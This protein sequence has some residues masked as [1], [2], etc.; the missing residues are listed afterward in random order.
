MTARAV[1]LLLLL[2]LV[3][4]ASW[5]F[6][7]FEQYEREEYVGYRGE[8]RINRYLGTQL[9]L[10]AA[11]FEA[12][13]LDGIELERWLPPA[14]DT[15]LL[16]QSL[17]NDLIG[18]R[19]ALEAWLAEGGHL[20][21]FPPDIETSR[22]D[23]L[24]AMAGVHTVAVDTADATAETDESI[25]GYRLTRPI[26][27]RRLALA[28]EATNGG[29]IA[30]IEDEFGIVAA[31]L[32]RGEGYLTVIVSDLWLTNGLIAEPESARF[33]LDLLAGAIE[34]GKVWI[35]FDEAI[36]GLFDRLFEAMPGVLAGIAI[37]V[38]LWLWSVVPRFGPLSNDSDYARRSI[39][40]HLEAAGAFS[41]RHDG[42]GSLLD[43]SIDALVEDAERRHPGLKKLPPE[44]QAVRIAHIT[45]LPASLIARA[46]S[47]V[48]E[49]TP[50][51]FTHHMQL[52][53]KVRKQL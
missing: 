13:S 49:L 21:T 6:S 53:Q 2:A 7:E 25:A 38:A 4:A 30:T 33:A 40:E 10:A 27:E 26:L 36:P 12:E 29:A 37:A 16:P 8:A 46:L 19:L 43:G 35:V 39:T 48:G 3:L 31:R 5:F 24:I 41:F 15:L 20:V 28:D 17:R 18:P 47:G 44:E 42:G 1:I 45:G 50:R 9:L 22:D 51:A 23:S 11:G 34:P 52:L 14:A 32:P